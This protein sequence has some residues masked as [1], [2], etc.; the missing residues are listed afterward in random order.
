M[1]KFLT[2]IG[3]KVQSLFRDRD[4]WVGVLGENR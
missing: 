2:W 3:R 4:D 1:R